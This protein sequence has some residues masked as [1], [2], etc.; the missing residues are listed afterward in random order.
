MCN[1]KSSLKSEGIAILKKLA[2][3][4][5]AS[6][7][8]AEE[9]VLLSE[10]PQRMEANKNRMVEIVEAVTVGFIHCA[11]DGVVFD[12]PDKMKE[13]YGRSLEENYPEANGTFLKFA[14]TYWT[15]KMKI[16]GI[17]HSGAYWNGLEL[18]RQAEFNIAC[19]FFP[20]PGPEK[21]SYKERE[22]TQRELLEL[23]GANIDIDKFIEGNSILIRDKQQQQGFFTRLFGN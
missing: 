5:G 15:F 8:E 7:A 18:L 6:I 21:I 10:D 19:L 4:G 23:S 22:Q 16:I 3:K 12:S 2:S 13:I 11:S 17:K 9:E 1:N 14:K 20:T